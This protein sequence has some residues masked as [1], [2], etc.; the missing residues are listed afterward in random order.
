M[1]QHARKEH[2]G[3]H[4]CHLVKAILAANHELRMLHHLCAQ[5]VPAAR[6]DP[7]VAHWDIL[8]AVWQPAPTSAAQ[9]G[10]ITPYLSA[11]HGCHRA[12]EPIQQRRPV[13]ELGGIVTAPSSTAMCSFEQTPDQYGT[14]TRITAKYKRCTSGFPTGSAGGRNVRHL[15]RLGFPTRVGT[16]N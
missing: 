1:Q 10:I 9:A 12:H 5:W 2:D 3:C 11:I 7:I 15:G 8:S 14:D 13:L 4:E 6:R 16:W